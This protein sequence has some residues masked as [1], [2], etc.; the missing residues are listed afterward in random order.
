M[1]KK[2]SQVKDLMPCLPSRKMEWEIEEE[3]KRVVILR[4]KYIYPP[5]RK[6]VEP[7]LKNKVFKIKLDDLGSVVWQ[8]C[9]GQTTVEEIGRILAETFGPD[10]EP[11]YDRLSKFI[12]QLQREKFI[13]LLCPPQE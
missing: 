3:S 5:V 4:P 1:G 2:L 10:I 6:L 12:I 9:N 13:E 8:N 11:I 7:F